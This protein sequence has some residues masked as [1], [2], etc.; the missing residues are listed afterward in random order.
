MNLYIN[1]IFYRCLLFQCFYLKLLFSLFLLFTEHFIVLLLVWYI[2]W[3][4]KIHFFIVE[5]C[6][7]SFICYI[8]YLYLYYILLL[9]T[10][11]LLY[12]VMWILYDSSNCML[13]A[14]VLCT[15]FLYFLQHLQDYLCIYIIKNAALAVLSI[16]YVVVCTYV[17]FYVKKN[18]AC[19]IS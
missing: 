12:F 3:L 4:H 17:P 9:V 19:A 2:I 11:L 16:L 14:S 5:S 6:I 7:G 18:I 1:V 13:Y 8:I 10:V 15:F